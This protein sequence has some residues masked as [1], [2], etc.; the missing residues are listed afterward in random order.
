MMMEGIDV[1]QQKRLPNYLLDA[2]GISIDRMPM[3][4]VIFD[5][6]AASCT[7]SLQP[8]AGTPCYFSVNDIS[9][10]RVGDV[11]KDYEGNAVAAVLYAEQWDA[12]VLVMLDRDFVFTM[13]EALFGSDGAEPP[14][15]VERAFSNIELRVVQ[16]LFERFAKALQS[17]F[18]ATSDVTFKLERVETAMASLA[19]G[20]SS[21][22]SVC[23]NI[24]LQALYRGGQMFLII[25]HSALNPLRQKLAHVVVSDGR[26]ADPNWRGQMESEVQR[27]E[28]TLNAVLDECVLSL[29]EVAQF[30]VGQVIE[31]NATPRTLARL[32]NNNQVLFWCQIGQLDGYY[33]MQVADPVDQKREFVDDILSR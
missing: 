13:V 8:M 9:N 15:D 11:V 19:I 6:M 25:P 1:E 33:A 4:N 18:A 10:A 21:N 14:I 26:A 29:G 17:A 3:L 30:Q 31:L 20:R 28:V 24:M 27:T 2:A 23:A 5:R 22:M 32:E 7:D 16:V 12:R